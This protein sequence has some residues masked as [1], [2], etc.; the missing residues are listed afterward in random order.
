MTAD[1]AVQV[2][3]R[4]RELYEKNPNITIE[5]VKANLAMRD[6]IYSHREVSPLRQAP[7]ALVLDNSRLTIRQQLDIALKWAKERQMLVVNRES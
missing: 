5:E 7:D 2:E 4:F 1:N 6:Y 3:R